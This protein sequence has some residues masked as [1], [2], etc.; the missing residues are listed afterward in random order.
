VAVF[1]SATNTLFAPIFIGL[2]VFGPEN[3]IL[4]IVVCSLAYIF[5]GNKTIYTGQKKYNYLE[6]IKG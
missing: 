3:M 5:N 4:Y 6:S 1:G 2:E